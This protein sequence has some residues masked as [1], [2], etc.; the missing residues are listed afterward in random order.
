MEIEMYEKQREIDPSR[1][2]E[3]GIHEYRSPGCIRTVC[4]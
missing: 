4:E 3:A 1:Q 2:T